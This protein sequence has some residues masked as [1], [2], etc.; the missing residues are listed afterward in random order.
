HT[1]NETDN[2]YFTV[3]KSYDQ[4]QWR[5]IGSAI[6]AGTST[7]GIYEAIDYEYSQE[8]IYYR[9]RQTDL[10]GKFAYSPTAVVY[11]VSS[12]ASM[13]AYPNPVV[14]SFS[15]ANISSDKIKQIQVFNLSG[16]LQH[17]FTTPK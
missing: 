10:D 11:S 12:I 17:T 9:I 4:R 14:N 2:A 3:E 16:V 7:S 6:A 5:S 13:Y 8:Q 15:I 1:A